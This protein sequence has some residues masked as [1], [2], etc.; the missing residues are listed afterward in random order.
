MAFAEGSIHPIVLSKL[1]FDFYC[2]RKSAHPRGPWS[3]LTVR[4]HS[5]F[6]GQWGSRKQSLWASA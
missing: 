5:A 2:P 3:L 4:Q 1:A 6:S